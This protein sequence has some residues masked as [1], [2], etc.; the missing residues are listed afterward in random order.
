MPLSTWI[1]VCDASHARLLQEKP[2]GGKLSLIGTYEHAESRAHVRDLTADAQGRKPVGP[3]PAARVTGQGGGYGRPGVEPETD[4][5]EVEA[6]KFARELAE[7][8][9]KG[10]N[11]H[12][13][14]QVVI[15]APPHFLGTLRGAMSSQVAKHIEATLDKDL[16]GLELPELMKRFHSSR[17]GG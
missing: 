5:K 7:V 13:Y 17:R 1:L 12:A 15:A 9:E 8:L 14:E 16:T 6:Q 10:R 11:D 4:A 2:R 3:V